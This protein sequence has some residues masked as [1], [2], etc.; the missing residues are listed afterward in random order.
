MNPEAIANDP[1]LWEEY[2]KA[3]LLARPYRARVQGNREVV[4]RVFATWASEPARYEVLHLANMPIN[5]LLGE[6]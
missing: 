4:E 1:E 3:V 2:R 5:A 6:G